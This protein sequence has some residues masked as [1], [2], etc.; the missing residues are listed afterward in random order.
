MRRPRCRNGAGK[1]QVMEEPQASAA[2]PIPIASPDDIVDALQ[3][4]VA[5]GLPVLEPSTAGMLANL[6]SVYARAAVPG[7]PMSRLHTLNELLPRLIAGMSDANYRAGVQ[8]L[9]GLAPGTRGTNLT[10]RRRQCADLMGY[11]PSYFRGQIETKLLRAVAM[12]LHEDLLRYQRRV[13]RATT[14]LEPTGQTPSLGP[15]HINHEEELI[16]R[17][18]QQ[19]YALRAETIAVVRLEDAGRSAEAEDHRQAAS[20]AGAALRRVLQE[21]DS[22]YGAQLIRHGDAELSTEALRRLVSWTP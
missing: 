17:I 9:F 10:A 15:E 11:N 5:D 12:T 13:K 4:V 18:W 21:Y 22:T 14:G 1:L 3:T 2:G 19:V 8:I 20:Q 7:E 6:R 16:S